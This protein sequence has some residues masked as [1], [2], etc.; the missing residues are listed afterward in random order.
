MQQAA[1]QR[2]VLDIYLPPPVRAPGDDTR[3]LFSPAHSP[4]RSSLVLDQ[5]A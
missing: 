5:P 3:G 1:D 4:R 2:Q